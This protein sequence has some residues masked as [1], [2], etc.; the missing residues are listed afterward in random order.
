MYEVDEKMLN[1]LDKFEGCPSLYRRHLE[2]VKP[3]DGQGN[4]S[5]ISAWVFAFHG[6][7]QKL[8]EETLYDTYVCKNYDVLRSLSGKKSVEERAEFFRQLREDL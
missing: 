3:V 7:H 8:L 2:M 6:F 4:A 1:F 5:S